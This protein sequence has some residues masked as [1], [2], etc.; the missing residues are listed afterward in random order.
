MTVSKLE[1]DVQ[2]FIVPTRDPETQLF[3]IPISDITTSLKDEAGEGTVDLFSKVEKL[4]Q[5]RHE[6]QSDLENLWIP[7][8]TKSSAS[9]NAW[10]HGIST[11]KSRYIEAL[12]EGMSLS[13]SCGEIPAGGLVYDELYGYVLDGPFIFGVQNSALESACEQPLF[14]CEIVPN[15]FN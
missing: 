14:A 1:N 10:L 8:F 13:L 3:F 6:A 4:W 12:S 9:S 11:G 7:N 2:I 15:D 5:S